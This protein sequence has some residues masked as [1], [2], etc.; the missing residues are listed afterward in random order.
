MKIEILEELEEEFQK[1]CKLNELEDVNKEAY[2]CFISGFNVKKY[3]PT[4][5]GQKEIVEKVIEVE[6]IIEKIIEIEVP[7]TDDTKMQEFITEI[8]KLKKE[9]NNLEDITTEKD[10]QIQTLSSQTQFYKTQVA[11]LQKEIE[12]RNGPLQRLMR[13]DFLRGSN[14]D[15]KLYDD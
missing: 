6:K 7:I 4:P 5:I 9:Y 13:G 8:N 10:T 3:G 14:L 1:F 15:N 12:K 11:G 2:K